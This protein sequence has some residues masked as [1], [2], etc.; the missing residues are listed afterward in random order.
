ML[1]FWARQSLCCINLGYNQ[2]RHWVIQLWAD[3]PDTQN[4]LLSFQV[5]VAKQEVSGQEIKGCR[6]IKNYH[7]WNLYPPKT[8]LIGLC[9]PIPTHIS[10]FQMSLDCF[11][12]TRVL[13]Q[14]LANRPSYVRSLGYFLLLKDDQYNAKS[15]PD[16]FG[17]FLCV[18]S[19]V[20]ISP[21]S[22]SLKEQ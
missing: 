10:I 14:S 3:F 22:T 5:L 15:T 7:L 9:G 21:S 16:E 19:G 17:L 12:Y 13:R 1:F 4:T 11:F 2:Y 18:V 20:T 6:Q 8:G